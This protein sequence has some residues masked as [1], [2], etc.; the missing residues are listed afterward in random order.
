M[1]KLSVGVKIFAIL[2][3][4]APLSILL[5]A[6]SPKTSQGDMPPP[7]HPRYHLP[8]LTNEQKEAI[9]KREVSFLKGLVEKQ[10]QIRAKEA[11]LK[12]LTTAESPNMSAIHTMIDE[13][14]KIKA[15]IAKNR[16]QTDMDIRKLLN[17][18]QRLVFDTRP[19]H[20]PHPPHHKGHGKPHRKAP[21]NMKE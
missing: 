20:P 19:M 4:F 17:E 16:I 7:P 2:L 21:E 12:A 6:Q 18:E 11:K 13:I 15:D 10:N 5:T 1:K 9:K 8:D 3:F 14:G